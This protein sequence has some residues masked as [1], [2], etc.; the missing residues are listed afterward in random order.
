MTRGQDSTRE[1][2][3][4]KPKPLREKERERD[5]WEKPFSAHTLR[6]L[7]LGHDYLACKTHRDGVSIQGVREHLVVAD[8]ILF[9]FQPPDS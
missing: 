6:I 3:Y 5:I 7:A 1:R 9:Y 4:E 8:F 2:T